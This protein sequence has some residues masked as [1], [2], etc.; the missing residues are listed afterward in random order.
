MTVRL[1]PDG[2]VGVA[3]SLP[4]DACDVILPTVSRVTG[5]N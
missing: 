4:D 1:P 3:R 2:D 5:V